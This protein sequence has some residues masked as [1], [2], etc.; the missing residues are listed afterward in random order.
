MLAPVVGF[1]GDQTPVPSLSAEAA[2]SQ[3]HPL[4]GQDPTEKTTTLI[5]S[6]STQGFGKGCKP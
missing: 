4:K 6:F 5:G 1:P 2:D 3:E